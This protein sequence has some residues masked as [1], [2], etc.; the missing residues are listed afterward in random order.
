MTQ[1]LAEE[2][3]KIALSA[4][5]TTFLELVRS[6]IYERPNSAYRKLLKH[7]GCDFSDLRA[8][9]GRHGLDDTLKRLARE[10]VYLTA[11]EF[12]GKKEVVR[13]TSVFRVS[14]PEFQPARN[15]AGFF[16]QSSG[17]SNAPIASFTP[18]AW[19]SARALAARV[20]FSAHEL[21]SYTHALFDA[22]LPGGGGI[23]N[24]LIYAKLGQVVERWFARRMPV[25][26]R[27]EQLYHYAN[28]YLIVLGGRYFGPGLPKP[29]FI[30][31]QQ[32]H[33]IIDWLSMKKRE[34]ATCCITT[35]ASNAARIAK[36]AWDRGV[37]LAG[38][39]F[40]V[41][42]EPFTD[43]KRAI[44]D[45]V[46]ARATSRYAYGGSINVGFGC[47]N[48]V[49]TDE[50]H[51]NEHMLALVARPTPVAGDKPHIYPLLC[52]TL[53][54]SAPRLLLNV[55]NGDYA[56]MVR[57]DCGCALGKVGL[58]LHLHHI[59]SYEKFTTEGMNYSCHDL[60]ELVEKTIPDE[61]GGGPGDY[62]LVEEEDVH[63]RTLLTLLARPEL[64]DLNEERLLK[65]LHDGFAQGSRGNKFMARVWQDTGSVRIRRAAPHASPRGKILPLH[66][67]RGRAE[68]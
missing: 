67:S 1:Q 52:T 18:L 4:R 38:T 20:F 55:E 48:P 60:F 53:H 36:E 35:P 64:G 44:L 34:K 8:C 21:F 61:F 13:G 56:E 3:I 43:S 9:I 12:K 68:S 15:G 54:P 26:S 29:E 63:G 37:S 45:R 31:R 27:L 49:G 19:L 62:Q 66:L 58:M 32:I 33:R 65:R 25:T 7:A 2:E 24:L 39:K 11:A 23:N 50:I 59:R 16:I 5:D 28:T 57:R 17:T 46:E 42:G 10:G 40:I 30:G 47:A 22:I 14:P 41:S 6:R 51:V